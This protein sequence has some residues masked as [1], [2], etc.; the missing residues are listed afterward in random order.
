M[1]LKFVLYILFNIWIIIGFLKSF[2]TLEKY[3]ITRN[4]YLRILIV[5]LLFIGWIYIN[6]DIFS[7]YFEHK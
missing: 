4:V 3:S 2:R 7:T 1:T 5:L 6:V